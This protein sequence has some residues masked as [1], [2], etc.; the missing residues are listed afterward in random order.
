MADDTPSSPDA[1]QQEIAAMEARL[2]ELRRLADRERIAQSGA[3]GLAIG[4]IAG[5]EGSVV[6]GGDVYGHI[7]HVYQSAPGR[8]SLRQE[9]VERI[10]GDYLRWVYNA[11]SKARLYGLESSPTARGR[12]VR[13]L[14]EVFVHVTLR[15]V[16][17]PR[18][19]EVEER[20]REMLHGPTSAWLKRNTRKATPYRFRVCL[21]CMTVWP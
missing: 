4:G 1:L 8:M 11:Y 21:P 13:A 10:L 3:G 18:R 19:M 9:D 15:R 7:Y 17:P 6:I 20:A 12:P 16:Q 5:G 14:A 2:A